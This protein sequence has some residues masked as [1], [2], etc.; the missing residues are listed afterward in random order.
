MITVR[1]RVRVRDRIRDRVGLWFGLR[2]NK[3]RCSTLLSSSMS[4]GCTVSSMSRLR[5]IS[6][7]GDSSNFFNFSFSVIVRSKTRR[8]PSTVSGDLPSVI[9]IFNA[10]FTASNEGSRLRF[11]STARIRTSSP[12]SARGVGFTAV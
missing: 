12:T 9:Y 2:R 7:P 5:T 10:V 3:G 6:S 11:R 4:E 8:S 1:I